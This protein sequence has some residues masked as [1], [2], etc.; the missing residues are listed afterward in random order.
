MT[1]R[2]WLHRISYHQEVSYPLLAK[3]YLTIGFSDFLKNEE[4]LAAMKQ[5]TDNRWA[6]FEQENR[7]IWGEKLRKTRYNLWRFLCEFE[8]GDWIL[9]P[10]WGTFSVYE[11][12]SEPM[13]AGSAILGGV[14]DW[15]GN[16]VIAGGEGGRYLKYIDGRVIDLGFALKVK[17]VESG[18][19]RIGYADNDLLYGMKYRMTNKEMSEL[20]DKICTAIERFRNNNPIDIYTETVNLLSDKLKDVIMNKVSD[21]QFEKLIKFYFERIGADEVEIPSKQSGQGEADGDVIATFEDIKL[22]IY[23]QAKHHTGVTNCKGV[24]QVSKYVEQKERET[25]DNEYSSIAW[26]I[27]SADE[28]TDEAISIAENRSVRLIN[29]IEFRKMLIDAGIANLGKGFTLPNP[30]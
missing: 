6:L 22:K 18:I 7:L 19:P 20:G 4:F 13:V 24:N 9:V 5:K 1:R 27:T 14:K 2:Y 16:D 25:D 29:G 3:G 23:V 17:I 28:F 15:N 26:V 12:I 21:D 10:S 30:S 11:V 8:I